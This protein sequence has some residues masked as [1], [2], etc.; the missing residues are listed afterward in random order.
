MGQF[1]KSRNRLKLRGK[2]VF[3]KQ[4]QVIYM[5]RKMAWIGFS[6]L[7]GLFL[8]SFFNVRQNVIIAVSAFLIEV[9]LFLAVKNKRPLI[10]I[11]SI[12]VLLAVCSN[13]TYTELVYNKIISYNDKSVGFSGKI[14]DINEQPSDKVLLTLKGKIDGKTGAEI[15]VFTDMADMDYDDK[16][17][18]TGTM[19][20]IEN[21][22]SFSS[23]DYYKPKGIY[24]NCFDAKNVRVTDVPFS[25]KRYIM[26]YRDFLFDKINSI[27][28]GEEGAFI[29]AMLCGDK[30][31]MSQSVKLSLYRTG[32]GHIFAVS[33]TH[34]V[35]I[36]AIILF[37]LNA[38]KLRRNIRFIIL[39]A[40]I[41]VF[42]VFSGASSSVIRA[43]IMLTVVFASDLFNRKSDTLNTLGFC[44]VLLTA[45]DPFLIKNLSFVLS[46]SGAFSI[47]V[48]APLVIKE[49]S[50]KGRFKSLKENIVSLLTLSLCMLP[51]SIFCFNEVSLISPLAN[52]L[53]IPI[54]SIALA[55]A[56]VVAFFGGISFVANTLLITAGLGIKVVLYLADLFNKIPFSYISTGNIYLKCFVV[57][58][59]IISA[60]A[61]IRY[62]NS[63]KT[64]FLPVIM[65]AV[66]VVA[67]TTASVVMDR[68]TLH[69]FLLSDNVSKALLLYKGEQAVIIDLYGRGKMS[70]VCEN[71]IEKFGIKSVKALFI[72]NDNANNVNSN[73]REAIYVEIDNS[74]RTSEGLSDDEITYVSQNTVLKTNGFEIKVLKDGG[75][76]ISYGGTTVECAKTLKNSLFDTNVK[77]LYDDK[78]LL[79]ENTDISLTND[80]GD[81]FHIAIKNGSDFSVRRLK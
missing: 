48:A 45:F 11:V 54:C 72:N 62:R 26:N 81:A 23:E 5:K 2:V 69:L 21:S 37:L 34:L 59:V 60:A 53:L 22:V 65:S 3:A 71:Y 16:I 51:L 10:L 46:M 27:L 38:L 49:C 9:L 76:L 80:N 74:F 28:P 4:R 35:I 18:F 57:L 68:G 40:F 70:S 47:G 67:G 15:V 17:S 56:V 31:E 8:A 7:F 77:I 52:L 63:I 14:V 61:L 6:Y 78:R 1:R 75:Y 42:V 25:L 13:I 20:K 32:I 58:A 39:E 55:L 73:Y 44:A 12:P 66:L 19:Q 29:G 33:G 79:Y 41:A 36:T 50:F 43:G 24:L 30:S 64:S